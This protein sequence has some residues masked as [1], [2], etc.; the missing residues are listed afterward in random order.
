LDGKLVLRVEEGAVPTASRA[1]KGERTSK[2][3]IKLPGPLAFGYCSS[4]PSGLTAPKD[5]DHVGF[6]VRSGDARKE[7]QHYRKGS[8]WETRRLEETFLPADGAGERRRP[9][10]CSGSSLGND[11]HFSLYNP[12]GDAR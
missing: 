9:T 11:F 7:K 8:W 5:I 12:S 3:S 6:L 4:T 1:R 10:S 2:T